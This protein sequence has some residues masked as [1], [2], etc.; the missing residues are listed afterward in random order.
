MHEVE[1]TSYFRNVQALRAVAALLVLAF[2]VYAV[3]GKYFGQHVVPAVLGAF[4]TCG[5]DLFFVISGFV[6]TTVTRGQFGSFQSAA[7]FLM[8][9]A[10]RIYPIYWVYSLIVLAVMIV[11]PQWVNASAGH[12]AEIV[13]SFLL[14]PSDTLPLL[15]QG[16]T[17]EYEIFFY[18]VFAVLLAC[19]PERLLV[20]ALLGWAAATCGLKFWLAS[21]HG[22][23]PAIRLAG[24]PLVLEF[25]MGCFCAL[26]WTA[27]RKPWPLL[28]IAAGVVALCVS[29]AVGDRIGSP[30]VV[31]WRSVYFG[32][33]AFFAVLGA[34]SLEGRMNRVAPKALRVLGDASYSLYLSHVLVISAVGRLY[35]RFALATLGPWLGTLLCIAAAI[36]AGYL[37]FKFIERPLNNALKR[38]AQRTGEISTA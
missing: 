15:L 11:M 6:M 7:G 18:V 21:G 12:H 38:A 34:V 30:L 2:H 22:A 4:G 9:R 14:L 37:S 5:V 25:I 28:F 19:L 26:T 10:M 13:R 8:R 20:I 1:S 36:V 29:V 32:V 16:W 33:P 23:G 3:E 31:Q 17:L 35:A 27:I 24:D